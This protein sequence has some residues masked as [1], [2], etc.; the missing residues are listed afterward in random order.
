MAELYQLSRIGDCR[1]R[2]ADFAIAECRLRLWDCR[3]G[4]SSVEWDCRLA[5]ASIGQSAI[6]IGTHQSQSATVNRK[7]G[8]RHP[9]VANQ[10]RGT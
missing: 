10:V 8:N 4:L 3:V 2:I 9:A 1:L 7:I 5:I 6:S